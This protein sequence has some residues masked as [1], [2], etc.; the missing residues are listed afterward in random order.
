M[1]FA[2]D[3]IVSGLKYIGGMFGIG[4]SGL[5]DERALYTLNSYGIIL[6]ILF[7]SC[8]GIP[9]KIVRKLLACLENHPVCTTIVTNVFLVAVFVLSVAYIVDASYNPFL[10]FRF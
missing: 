6:L 5:Y 4:V 1:I 2:N 3:S 9:K 10:Y 7:I 8:T